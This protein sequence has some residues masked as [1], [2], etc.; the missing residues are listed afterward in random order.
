MNSRIR[1]DIESLCHSISEAAYRVINPGS[2]LVVDESLFEYNG[3]CP[4]RRYIPRKPHP[5]GLLVYGLAGYFHFGTTSMPFCLDFEPYVP[6]NLVSPQSAMTALLRRARIRRPTLTPHL[7]V[8]SAFGSLEKLRE[9]RRLGAHA[10]MSMPATSLKGVWE[11]LDFKCGVDEGRLA[12]FPN[13]NFVISSFKVISETR[14]IHVIKTISSGCELAEDLT[15]ESDVSRII[16]RRELNNELEYQVEFMDGHREWL[17]SGAFID[18]DGTVNITWLHYAKEDDLY[19]AFKPLTHARL[20][21]P[22]RHTIPYHFT[23]FLASE[24]V[25]FRIF[26]SNKV[27]KRAGT[28][29]KY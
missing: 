19:R 14:K 27:G 3:E 1:Y 24:L 2:I 20:R 4:V 16:A 5:N 12:H 7:F 29:L 21:V 8:D 10:T 6:N 9:I 15:D 11:L 18:D 26:A 23:S 25:S 17:T 13:E 22:L 28:R